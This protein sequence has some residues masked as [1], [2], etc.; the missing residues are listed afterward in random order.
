MHKSI[1]YLILSAGFP[2]GLCLLSASGFAQAQVNLHNTPTEKEMYCS[3]VVTDQAVD[4]QFY[5]ISG[6][7]SVYKTTFSG[8]DFIYINSGADHGVRVGDQFDVVRPISDPMS[9]TPWF[10]YQNK[11]SRAMGTRYAD[12]GRL[13]VIHVEEK[14]STAEVTMSCDLFQRGDIVY[15][16]VARPVPQF[17][18]IKLDPFAPPSGKRTAMVVSAKEYMDLYGPGKVVYINLGGQQGV[19]VGDYFRVFRYQGSYNDSNYQVKNSSYK[20]TGFGTAPVPYLW[21]NLPRQILGE[22]IVLRLGP[23]A[24]TVLLTDSREEIYAGDYVEL[25]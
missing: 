6:E 23:N 21:N 4:H 17:H 24:S 8:D 11:L 10:K 7:D 5:I 16:F 19:R 12:I 25:E 18:N 2:F 14:T 22:G 1:R 15:Q 13:R 9:I 20:L 3:G